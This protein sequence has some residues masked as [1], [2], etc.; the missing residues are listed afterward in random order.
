[1]SGQTG[2]DGPGGQAGTAGDQ[3]EDE[4]GRGRGREPTL[5]LPLTLISRSAERET[6]SDISR[7]GWS[8]PDGGS[9]EHTT[10]SIGSNSVEKVAGR[11]P[12]DGGVRW[13]GRGVKRWATRRRSSALETRGG[14]CEL[15]GVLQLDLLGSGDGGNE[16][17]EVKQGVQ[18]Q[19][20]NSRQPSQG[21]LDTGPVRGK[22]GST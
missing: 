11:V 2:T 10:P 19:P 22:R 1:M 15:T 3:S 13:Q 18:N 9:I 7:P 8:V 4:R 21:D 5:T 6:A 20:R 16:G 12:G 14:G 17:A